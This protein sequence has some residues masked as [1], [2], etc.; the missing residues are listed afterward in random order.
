[1]LI[2][3]K[4]IGLGNPAFI[5]AELSANHNQNFDIAVETIKAAKKIGADAIKFQT[6]TADTITM[7]CDSKHFQINEGL[8]AGKTLYELY[9]EAYTPWEWQPK[10]KKIAEE[11]GLVCFSSAFDKTAVDFLEKMD[12]PA[13]KV[14]SLEITDIP[15]IQYIASKGKPVI[16]STGIA[17]MKD[18][19]EAVNACREM[20]NNN[21]I[22]FIL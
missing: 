15:L 9:Q 19:Q 2:G 16:M 13:Y 1:M 6:Y 12:V 20:G 17:R 22:L 11:L 3:N 4:K 7:N 8:W 14:A 10:L 5:I 21:I 18:I